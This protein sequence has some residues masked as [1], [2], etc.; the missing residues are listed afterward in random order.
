MSYLSS[1]SCIFWNKAFEV[2]SGCRYIELREGRGNFRVGSCHYDHDVRI[3]RE[4]VDECGE[5]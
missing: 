2:L 3:N 4:H 5:L 1:F